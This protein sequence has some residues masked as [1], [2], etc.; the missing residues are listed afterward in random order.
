MFESQ[1]GRVNVLSTKAS[2]MGRFA[3]IVC[4]SALAPE[5]P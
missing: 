2:P 3:G 4:E 1:G 5:Q